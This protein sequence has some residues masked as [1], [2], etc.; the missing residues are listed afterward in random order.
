[1]YMVFWH[2]IF[3]NMNN[4][5]INFFSILTALIMYLYSC[6]NEAVIILIILMIFDY[7]TG[8]TKLFFLKEPFSCEKGLIGVI[9]KMLYGILVMTG[10][11]TDYIIS[12]TSVDLGLDIKTNGFIGFIVVFYLIGN[13]GLSVLNNLVDCGVPMPKQLI[14]I[15]KKIKSSSK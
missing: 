11:L 9:R 6:I 13:E 3:K 15:Y 7:M 5:K 2:S 12:T 8:I 14:N 10:F 4:V 1:M